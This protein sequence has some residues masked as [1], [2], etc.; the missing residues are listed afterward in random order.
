MHLL[1]TKPLTFIDKK[2]EVVTDGHSPSVTKVPEPCCLMQTQ[3]GAKGCSSACKHTHCT[4]WGHG[5]AE[6]LPSSLHLVQISYSS[7]EKPLLVFRYSGGTSRE[8]PHLFPGLLGQRKSRRD[9]KTIRCFFWQLRVR[10]QWCQ[11]TDRERTLLFQGQPKW[12]LTK[13]LKMREFVLRDSTIHIPSPHL[14]PGLRHFL[15][16]LEHLG[17]RDTGYKSAWLWG[18]RCKIWIQVLRVCSP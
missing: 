3:W 16:L 7:A 6:I 5:P 9:A 11:L 8:H 12:E 1:K 2:S 10:L 18:V 14:L 15:F 17:Q 13:P 4:A